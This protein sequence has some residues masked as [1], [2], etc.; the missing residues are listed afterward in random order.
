MKL[1]NIC[2]VTLLIYA[3]YRSSTPNVA[4]TNN[5]VH[6]RVRPH[7]QRAPSGN[8]GAIRVYIFADKHYVRITAELQNR[9]VRGEVSSFIY[10]N[11]IQWATSPPA[12][13]I[14]IV[15]RYLAGSAAILTLR[16]SAPRDT[17][18]LN[19]TEYLPEHIAALLPSS[20]FSSLKFNQR[21]NSLRIC[22]ASSS[23][24][25]PTWSISR[26]IYRKLKFPYK[27]YSEF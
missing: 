7:V 26:V 21:N 4:I 3:H 17:I 10:E 25:I 5:K 15:G 19:N 16:R 8:F 13:P 9:R 11:K 23:V 6:H 20:S 27:V 2:D 24:I 1:A 22:N 12:E 14:L 18:V